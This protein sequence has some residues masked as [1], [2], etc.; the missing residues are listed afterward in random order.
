M[1]VLSST[2]E[3][4][5]T[6]DFAEEF[7]GHGIWAHLREVVM[8]LV[9]IA[10]YY[11]TK[12]KWWLWIITALLLSVQFLYMVK[13]AVIIAIV[14][15]M[16]MRLYAHKMH[17]SLSLLAKVFFRRFCHIYHHLHGATPYRQREWRGKYGVV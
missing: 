7:S 4:F 10:T 17:L 6:D 8:P 14:S 2:T 1:T 15:G 3:L 5:G 12:K 13:G 9:I 16:C 11:I